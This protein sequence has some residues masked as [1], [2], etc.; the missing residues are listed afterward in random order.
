[1]RHS[2]ILGGVLA[3][4][5]TVSFAVVGTVPMASAAPSIGAL[6]GAGER[7]G[8]TRLSFTAGDSVNAQVDVGS[9]NLLVTVRA[10]TRI[11]R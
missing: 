1:M 10:L 4:L 5:T 7:A 9:G 2:R 3:A 8:A 11:R 6:A